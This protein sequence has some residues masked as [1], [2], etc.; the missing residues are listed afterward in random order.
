MALK[1]SHLAPADPTERRSRVLNRLI[2]G[3]PLGVLLAIGL[4]GHLPRRSYPRPA[5]TAGYD[6]RIL[7]YRERVAAVDALKEGANPSVESLVAEASRWTAGYASGALAAIPADVYEDHLRDSPRGEIVRSG[8]DLS[9]RL[10]TNAEAAIA[11][12]R[13]S[14]GA[15]EALLGAE[16]AFGMRGF[17]IQGHLASLLAVRRA[18]GV[19]SRAWPSIPSAERD[20][21]RERLRTLTTDPDEI[22]AL[23]EADA[24]NRADYDRRWHSPGGL[25]RLSVREPSRTAALRSVRLS[26]A[27]LTDLMKGDATPTSDELP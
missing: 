16:T 24:R 8:L 2:V 23:L 10:T 6:R 27:R 19:M 9:A 21:I 4:V 18:I 5:S 7:A 13:F 14:E 22:D 3:A 17:D 25:E 1:R 15:S 11:R 12:R 26:N 20:A